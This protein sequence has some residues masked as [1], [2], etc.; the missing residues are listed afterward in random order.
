MHFEAIDH[1]NEAIK[2]SIQRKAGPFHYFIPICHGISKVFQRL[3]LY[4]LPYR[5]NQ[6]HGTIRCDKGDWA[7]KCLADCVLWSSIATHYRNPS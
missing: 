4:L 5:A 6:W 7:A 1:K 2:A 3:A